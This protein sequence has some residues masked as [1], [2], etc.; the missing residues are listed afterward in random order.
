MAIKIGPRE[1]ALRRQREASERPAE[2]F[3]ES[4]LRAENEALR[5]EVAK[6]KRE[7]AARPPAPVDKPVDKPVDTV[8]MST[9]WGK[10]GISR[11]AYYNRKQR[12]HK[13]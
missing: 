5:A 11:D 4:G 13:P 7:L 6:L 2:R 3:A 8:D 1:E 12:E 9:P 10:L